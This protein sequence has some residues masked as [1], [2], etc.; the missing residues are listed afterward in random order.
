MAKCKTTRKW[1]NENYNCISVSYCGIQSLL[2][3]KSP[4]FYTCGVYGWN[5]DAYLLTT[6]SGQT[7]CLTTGYRG[8]IDNFPNNNNYKLYTKYDQKAEAVRN[9]L[10]LTNYEE[11]VT[12]INNLLLDYLDEVIKE[13]TK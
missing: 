11:K 13:S 7:I 3:G 4:T 10:S 9:N 12:T 6:R 8:M 5:C 2:Y 1:L